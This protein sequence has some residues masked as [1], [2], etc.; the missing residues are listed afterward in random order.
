MKVDDE[1]P[2]PHHSGCLHRRSDSYSTTRKSNRVRGCD[3]YT[4]QERSKLP[5]QSETCSMTETLSIRRSAR[6]R[7][8]QADPPRREPRDP[9]RRNPR[10]DGP[11]R[12]RQ[13]HARL[14]HHGPPRLRGDRRARSNSNGRGRAGD[15]AA[16]AGPARAVPGLP[17]AD[18]DSRREDGRLPAPRHDQRPPS[19]P[20]GRRGADPD[21]GVPQGTHARRWSSCGWTPS[22]PAA[23]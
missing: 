19:R 12:L 2:M 18:G 15:G 17:A 23:T 3:G 4:G 11:Q 9:P 13:E 7:R 14:R 20:Q 5:S 6:Q 22:S 16:R 10:P 21:A 8:R 1:L